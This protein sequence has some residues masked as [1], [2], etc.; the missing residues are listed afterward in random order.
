MLHNLQTMSNLVIEATDGDIGRC[1]DFLF[2]DV[3]WKIRYMVAD[4]GKWLPGR[5]VLITPGSLS[6]IDWKTNRILVNLSTD[7][8][9]RSP[10]LDQD[11]PVSRRYEIELANHYGAGYW[12]TRSEGM[13]IMPAP[14]PF[15]VKSSDVEA[16]EKTD[17]EQTQLRSFNEVSGYRIQATDDTLGHLETMLVDD[18]QWQLDFFVV[19]TRNWLP[20]KK[21]VIPI[22]WAEG[23]SWSEETFSVN[24]TTDDI[25]E[26]PT[27]DLSQPVDPQFESVLRKRYAGDNPRPQP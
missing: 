18:V 27:I 15:P 10:P 24:K 23:V 13:G 19:D 16:D 17:P 25:K 9:R 14:V 8:L 20:G 11:A 2:D 3:S 5:K 7:A 22:R 6:Q 1:S 4:T 21:V 12:W 26:C